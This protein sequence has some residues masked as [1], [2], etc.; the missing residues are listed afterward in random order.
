[1]SLGTTQ[2]FQKFLISDKTL[3]FV[4]ILILWKFLIVTNIRLY[5]KIYFYFSFLLSTLKKDLN[6]K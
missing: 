3:Y 5:L 1:M 4:V 6:W 2:W